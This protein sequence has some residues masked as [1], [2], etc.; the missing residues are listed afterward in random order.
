MGKGARNRARRQASVAARR[1]TVQLSKPAALVDGIP[2]RGGTPIRLPRLDD[3]AVLRRYIIQTTEDEGSNDLSKP[4][5]IACPTSL[6]GL[7]DGKEG[8]R[9]AFEDAWVTLDLETTELVGTEI[10]S[11]LSDRGERPRAGQHHTHREQRASRP[12]GTALHAG[13]GDRGHG[14]GSV[15]RLGRDRCVQACSGRPS[16]KMASTGVV[17]G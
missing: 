11:E 17:L 1:E 15:M 2:A 5:P 8:F 10:E 4:V 9:N 13:R 6:A 7:R 14:P 16:G 12:A 3:D